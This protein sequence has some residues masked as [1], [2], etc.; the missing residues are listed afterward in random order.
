M[1]FEKFIARRYIRSKQ[2]TLFINII[3]LVSLAGVT[4]GVAALII[5]LSVF[6][7]FNKVVTDVLVGFDPHVRILPNEGKSFQ[8]SDTL[9]SALHEA[10]VQGWS[11]Y[12]ESK[13]LLVSK[14]GNRVAVVKGVDDSTIGTVSGVRQATVAGKFDFGNDG[15]GIVVG[16]SL[17]DRLGIIVG[18]ELTI[19][20]PVGIDAMIVQYTEPEMRR[21]TVT[22]IYDSRN[23]EYDTH[24]AFISIDVARKLFQFPKTVSGVE[25]RL[26]NIKEA[27]KTKLSLHNLLGEKYSV[28]SWYDLHKDLYSVMKIERWSAYIILCLII[29]V[30]TFNMLGSLTMGVIEKRRDIGILKSLGATNKSILRL[31]MFEGLL[32]GTV[33]T[34]LGLSIGL[35]VCYVQIHY[36]L[37]PLD[38]N[39]YIIPAI[40]VDVRWSDFLAIGCA[41]MLL[42]TLAALYPARRAA[43]LTPVDAIRWE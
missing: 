33:G 20:S 40:P 14:N 16:L 13:A 1:S 9:N 10:G 19:V 27:E 43:R 26:N 5:V 15:S 31:F 24:Y 4:V 6:N 30:A 34:V 23:K 39:V 18:S 21:F 17:A 3:M 38:P 36:Q 42:C 28:L 2:Q 7:G 8:L 11:P 32:V 12:V 37:F 29:G 41:S 25:V 22:G 35:V